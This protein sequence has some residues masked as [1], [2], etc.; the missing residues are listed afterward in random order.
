MRIFILSQTIEPISEKPT[1]PSNSDAWMV[2][3]LIATTVILASVA[4]TPASIKSSFLFKDVLHLTASQ[5]STL[6]IIMGIPAYLRPFM[7]A[8]ADLFPVFGFHRKSYYLIGWLLSATGSIALGLVH[9][10]S[11]ETVVTMSVISGFGGALIMVMA[12]A[13]MVS[14][15][16]QTGNVGRYQSLQQFLPMALGVLGLPLLAGYCAQHWSYNRCFLVGGLI[17]LAGVVLV[18]L[19]PEKRSLA[20]PHEGETPEEHAARLAAKQAERE[21]TKKALI[22][23]ARTPGLWVMVIYV[24]YLIVTPG[25]NTAQFY[26]CTNVLHF[27]PQFFGVLQT[28][29]SAGAAG[30]AL[31]FAVVSPR[32]PVKSMVWGAFLMDCL[33]YPIGLM[34]HDPH[35][36]IVVS[37]VGGVS[38]MV[39]ALCLYTLAARACPPGI[40]G[41]VYGLVIS[42]ITLAGALGDK[43]GSSIYDHFGPASHHSIAYGWHALNWFGF[44]FTIVAAVFIPFLPAWSRSSEPLRPIKADEAA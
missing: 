29:G 15:G 41:T 35:S 26:F 8:I 6:G 17:S 25:T 32:L 37:V 43:L 34:L 11:V 12:D 3:A 7:G 2:A 33:A 27:K 9:S 18:F 30:G 23:A 39:Y 1:V 44:A 21:K 14:V 42:A 40:E 31:L 38:G 16:N 10:Y 24:F 20:G 4:G 5:T 13:V 28:Y 19:M 36:A 22:D